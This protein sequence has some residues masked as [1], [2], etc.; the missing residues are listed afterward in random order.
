M[1]SI[2][3]TG[4]TSFTFTLAADNTG[5]FQITQYPGHCYGYGVIEWTQSSKAVHGLVA[6][7]D[8]WNNSGSSRYAIVINNG[9]P[10]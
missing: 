2:A 9:L 8:Y 1:F 5:Y 3:S 4:D 6:Y 10:F 7:G